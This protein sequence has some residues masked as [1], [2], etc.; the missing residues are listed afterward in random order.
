MLQKSGLEIWTTVCKINFRSRKFSKITQLQVAAESAA[1]HCLA[2]IP[3]RIS[4]IGCRPISCPTTTTEKE[5]MLCI[6]YSHW[7]LGMLIVTNFHC[8][9]HVYITQ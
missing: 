2:C 9:E 5:S 8:H 3:D 1:C 7:F 4:V 6:S